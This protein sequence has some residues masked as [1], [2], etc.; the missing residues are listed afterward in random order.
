MTNDDSTTVRGLGRETLL[1]PSGFPFST[2]ASSPATA[3]A[4]I[5]E[6]L[7]RLSV[8]EAFATVAWDGRAAESRPNLDLSN[9]SVEDFFERFAWN[10]SE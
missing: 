7:M 10:A 6:D 1:P 3:A 9:L 4:V 5:P 2:E 8:A